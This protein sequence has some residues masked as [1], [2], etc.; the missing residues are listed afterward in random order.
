VTS[1]TIWSAGRYEAVAE[2]IAPIATKVVD[3]VD[4]RTPVRD[5]TLID[6]ACGTGNA[7]IAAATRGARVTAIDIT[8]ELIA[9][10]KQKAN[11]ARLSVT[12]ITADASDTGLPGRIFDAVV[13]NMG[14]IFVEPTA[15]VSE[16]E[17]LLKAGGA[18]GFSSWVPDPANPFFRPIVDVLGPSPASGYSPD[19]WGESDSIT[20]RLAAGFDDIEIEHGL[21]TWQFESL[22]AG[23]HFVAHD[24][25]M[26][27]SVLGKVAA[28]QRDRLL[29]AFEV[30]LRAHIDDG[31][32]TFDAPYLVVTARRR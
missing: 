4:R 13:S 23:M 2:R 16:F 30:A 15:Q 6:L 26:H 28:G 29:A 24:S 21:H 31:G 22:D 8:P 25:P 27:V 14:I 10:A 9:I 19:Q 3:A 18:L 12:W 5:A 7:A 17:R 32:V 20:T 11:A 1:P